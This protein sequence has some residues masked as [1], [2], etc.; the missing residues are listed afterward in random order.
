MTTPNP[1]T[2][3]RIHTRLE[4][5]RP[6][7]GQATRLY[8][9]VELQAPLFAPDPRPPLDLVVCLDT[10]G[11]M[12]GRKLRE[13]RRAFQQLVDNLEPQDRAAL[14]SFSHGAHTVAP[15]TAVTGEGRRE[16]HRLADTL[17]S[18]GGTA[19]SH[20]LEA[21]LA[22]LSGEPRRFEGRDA[23][24]RVL[25]F[26]DGHANIG[27][28]EGDRHGWS[29]LLGEH[30]GDAAVSWFGFGEDHDPYFLSDLADEARG[31]A[32]A[33]RDADAIGTAFA[34]ELGS[35]FGLVARDLR[36]ALKG[37][38]GKPVVL[39]DE[40]MEATGQA[41]V[42][43]LADLT[44]EERTKVVFELPLDAGAIGD[45][46]TALEVDV[47]WFDLRTQR[48]E[49]ATQE[50]EVAF[51]APR[52]ADAPSPEVLE[53]VAVRK[54]A[55]AQKEAARLA[56]RGEYRR[57]E[58]LL[59]EVARIARGLSSRAGDRLAERLEKLAREHGDARFFRANRAML[60]ADRWAVKK[61]RASGSRYDDDFMTNGQ[62]RMVHRF[63]RPRPAN[64]DRTP[65]R[66]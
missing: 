15:P 33:A 19:M 52:S 59:L 16:L 2:Q 62:R 17:E 49:R 11:S 44:S 9:F 26:T 46:R 4:T 7:Q 58:A 43:H 42:V 41:V 40:R 61:G 47:R 54:A 13:A 60:N 27:L 14:V 53:A 29:Q 45:R 28:R 24:R 63:D 23:L 21:A 56:E 65:Q 6:A 8:G 20:G 37:A 35:L 31:N 39:N 50:A 25:V 36:I 3:I 30:L 34:Q 22:L 5:H 51:I 64:D 55:G 18:G 66:S 10:S 48:E 57:A 1:N 38:A 12:A 32:Y